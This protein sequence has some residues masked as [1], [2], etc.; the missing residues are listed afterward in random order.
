MIVAIKLIRWLIEKGAKLLVALLSIFI[1]FF[2]ITVLW[3]KLKSSM[4][5]ISRREIE[6][7]RL[8]A[9]LSETTE[10]RKLTE[11]QN[12]VE[13][14]SL[15]IN[16]GNLTGI[17][18]SIAA[19]VGRRKAQAKRNFELEKSKLTKDITALENSWPWF[20]NIPARYS[21]QAKIETKKN[22]LQGLRMGS[23]LLG[24]D[25]ELSKREDEAANKIKSSKTRIGATNQDIE[26]LR[27]RESTLS[28]QLGAL[29]GEVG[30]LQEM[31]RSWQRFKPWL[32]TAVVA[33]VFAPIIWA[34]V[35]YYIVARMATVQKPILLRDGSAAD[36]SC[37][38]P[39][40]SINIELSPGDA[41]CCQSE[42][43]TQH[44]K[45]PK[46]TAIFWSWRAIG[47][48][49]LSGL[50]LCT[51]IKNGCDKKLRL[52]LSASD[53][54]MEISE[55]VLCEDS[56]MVIHVAHIVAIKGD[57]SV[58]AKWR[59]GSLH[60]WLT[61]QFRYLL[62]RGAGSIFVA[63]PR[64]IEGYQLEGQVQSVEQR[65]IVGFDSRLLYSVKRTETFVAYLRG[66]ASLFDDCFSGSGMILRR[67]ACPANWKSP[68]E[69]VYGPVFAAIGKL[70]GF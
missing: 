43:L 23:A 55:I 1:V 44:D 60:S 28:H 18:E 19:E 9:A 32:L 40:T 56:E 21:H 29:L 61:G 51:R 59:F 26:D 13:Q 2:A 54:E 66:K 7:V 48:S 4:E 12:E 37:T 63:A 68:F 49:V 15:N 16:L 53:S 41:I 65:I 70:L 10:K 64:G 17:R 46:Q 45:C 36:L 62:F 52:A 35:L 8:E 6:Q 14:A 5:D 33:L 31:T 11:H 58:V 24:D 47:V 39:R 22:A 69:K 50:T 25:H 57:V 67:N 30:L 27:Q 38:F 20:W 42:L 3:P 34:A